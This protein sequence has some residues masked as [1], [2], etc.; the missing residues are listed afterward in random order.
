MPEL[1]AT[2]PAAYEA[3]ALRLA[4]SRDELFAL[5]ERL[6]RGRLNAPLFNVDR[7]AR[8]V[9]RAFEFMHKIW[10]TGEPPRAFS[11]AVAP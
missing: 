9:E 1:V 11:L 2:S 7:F 10:R 4:R 6:A 8:D 3:Q 5:R